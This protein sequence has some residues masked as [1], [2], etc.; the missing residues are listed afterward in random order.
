MRS[1]AVSIENNFSKGLITEAT[2]M[3]YPE[4]SV[5][6]TD[7]CVYLKTGKVIRRY[8]ID[9]ED[10]YMVSTLQE[11]GV[12]SGALAPED[13]YSDLAVVEFEWTTVDN[14][15]SI[16]FSVVQI[17]D[18]LVFYRVGDAND[19]SQNRKSFSIN[20]NDYQVTKGYNDEGQYIAELQVTFASGFGYLFVTHPRCNPIYVAYNST[21]DTITT[22]AITIKTRDF[23]RQNDGYD[24][25]FRPASLTD[26]HKYNLYN[27]GWYA[28]AKNA[29]PATTNVLTYWDAK[30]SDFPSNS[31]IWWAFKNASELLDSTLFDTVALGN[32]PAPSGHRKYR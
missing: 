17:G 29:D 2:A 4:N 3:N 6:E 23:D 14:N 27:Q 20:L 30:R 1:A 24:N 18:C 9:F 32:T 5:A 10:D 21:T 15:G 12:M 22:T 28:T 25:D 26:V 7:N 13:Y 16:V 19:I 11:L 8:G 31:D